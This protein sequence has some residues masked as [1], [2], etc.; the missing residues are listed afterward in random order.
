M[1]VL[2]GGQ[3]FT[4]Q[5]NVRQ[6]HVT[7]NPNWHVGKLV[8]IS[9]Q[10]LVDSVHVGLVTPRWAIGGSNNNGMLGAKHGGCEVYR[11]IVVLFKFHGIK[12]E[13]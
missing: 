6:I 9:R 10:C 4:F 1:R 7:T 11:G 13:N 3:L 5:F 8:A 12:S 2:I